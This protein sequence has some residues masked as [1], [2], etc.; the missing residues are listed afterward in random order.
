MRS[1]LSAKGSES[2]VRW[3]SL[4]T[5]SQS[6]YSV[7]EQFARGDA[8]LESTQNRYRPRSQCVW[9]RDSSLCLCGEFSLTGRLL[10]ST[11][12]DLVIVNRLI[13]R[14]PLFNECSLRVGN[15]DNL[16][17]AGTVPRN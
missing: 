7:V 10:Q 1:V 14:A 2:A 8:P 6:Q 12:G 17:L 15:L 9:D 3:R 16:R 4:R 13:Q 11:Q 5:R